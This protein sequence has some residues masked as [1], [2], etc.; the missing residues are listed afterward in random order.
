MQSSNRKFSRR[1]FLTV[2]VG[3]AALVAGATLLLTGDDPHKYDEKPT[4]RLF[5][6]WRVV[7]QIG[8][9]GVSATAAVPF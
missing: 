9:R 6:R 5:G 4:D 2:V 3:G 1:T 7:P 8:S